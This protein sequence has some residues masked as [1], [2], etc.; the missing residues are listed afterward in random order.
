MYD[1]EI[2]HCHFCGIEEMFLPLYRRP[3]GTT[4]CSSNLRYN[5]ELN[6]YEC[7][8]ADECSD[9]IYENEGFENQMREFCSGLE[10]EKNRGN[11]FIY[12]ENIPLR[13][14]SAQ[15][16]I[17]SIPIVDPPINLE[18]GM[19][20]YEWGDNVVIADANMRAVLELR[21]NG[22]EPDEDFGFIRP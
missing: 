9:N 11:N 21:K 17:D 10:Y 16:W 7:I 6:S 4:V 5:V 14:K 15:D 3:D 19:Y 1:E 12:S 13:K 22:S 20:M 18:D 2:P 8:D